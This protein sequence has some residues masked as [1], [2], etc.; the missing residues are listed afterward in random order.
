VG[1][2]TFFGDLYHTPTSGSGVLELFL[3]SQAREEYSMDQTQTFE[4]GTN[5]V[6][7]NPRR[8]LLKCIFL[9]NIYEKLVFQ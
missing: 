9:G 6:S 2:D 8:N 7:N 3:I 1:A 4:T 5:A